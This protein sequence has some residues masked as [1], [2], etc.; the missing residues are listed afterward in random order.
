MRNSTLILDYDA[1]LEDFSDKFLSD[2]CEKKHAALLS[3]THN[4]LVK[5]HNNTSSKLTKV[6][7]LNLGIN[8]YQKRHPLVTLHSLKSYFETMTTT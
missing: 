2:D 4:T 8:I 5:D 6:I 3:L 1:V 7:R